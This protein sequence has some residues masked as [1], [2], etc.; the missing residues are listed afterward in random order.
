MQSVPI[1]QLE[2]VIAPTEVSA[3]PPGPAWWLVAALVLGI[4]ITL[5]IMWRQRAQ[6]LE[7]KRE[8]ISHA[9]N[10]EDALALHQLLKRLCKHYYGDHISALTGKKWAQVLSQ[11]SAMSFSEDELLAIY[12]DK[13]DHT[14]L[15]LKLSS[16]INQFKTK[17]ILDV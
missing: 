6:H 17:E 10:T 4:L 16:A 12:R 2:D 14:D 3:W 7:A 15:S 5:I 9:A 1:P 8:A 13:A 11:L